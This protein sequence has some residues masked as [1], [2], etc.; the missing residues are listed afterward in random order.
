[1]LPIMLL[2]LIRLENLGIRAEDLHSQLV[3]W[4]I[5]ND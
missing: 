1:M 2:G 5:G 4:I 3:R